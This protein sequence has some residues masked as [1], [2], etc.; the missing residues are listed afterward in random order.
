MVSDPVH[1][2]NSCAGRIL[3]DRWGR[4]LNCFY[5]WCSR[6]GQ[7]TSLMGG[8]GW[9]SVFHLLRCSAPDFK[10]DLTLV[11]MEPNSGFDGNA[12]WWLWWCRF[13]C[14]K[15]RTQLAMVRCGVW[16]WLSCATTLI[17]LLVTQWQR[18]VYQTKATLCSLY[19]SPFHYLST[20]FNSS[21]SFCFSFMDFS[22]CVLVFLF[23]L[24]YLTLQLLFVLFLFDSLTFFSENWALF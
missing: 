24:N 10:Y 15:G 9:D 18:P 14:I 6:I 21:S 5:P 3:W 17:D 19:L 11:L 13:S 1:T 23:P 7:L 22:V 2:K 12:T 16:Y 4:W 8:A 20:L